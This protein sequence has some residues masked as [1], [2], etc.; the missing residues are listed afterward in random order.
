MR[1][2]GKKFIPFSK[3]NVLYARLEAY[4][5]SFIL[6]VMV[7]FEKDVS[8]IAILLSLAWAGYKLIQ[9]LY[10]KMAEREHLEELKQGRRLNNLDT[11]DLDIKIEE[12]E[13]KIIESEDYL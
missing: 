4:V 12:L 7:W 8:A 9:G 3:K 5:F 11:S 10:I 1:V 2:M 13:N 6:I